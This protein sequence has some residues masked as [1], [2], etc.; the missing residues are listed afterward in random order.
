MCVNAKTSLISFL[1][2]TFFNYLLYRQTQNINYLMIIAI[3]QSI[4]TIQLFDFFCWMDPACGL[5]NKIGTIGAFLHT[6]LQPVIIT[7]ILLQFTQVTNSNVLLLVK[8]VLLAYVGIVVYKLY[9]RS[10]SFPPVTCLKPS[11][12]CRHLQ[13]S[14][15]SAMSNYSIY[16]YLVPCLVSLLLLLKSRKLAIYNTFY[17]LMALLLSGTLY[18][19]GT[20]SMFCL[21]ATGAPLFNYLLLKNKIV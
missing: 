13:Y 18:S 2:G 21:F 10:S 19:C 4:L 20:P 1:V 15:W 14:W 12:K 16:I 9:F 11:S 7:L 6:M 17:I 3:F 5:L 8:V